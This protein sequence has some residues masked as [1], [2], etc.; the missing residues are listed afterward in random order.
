MKPRFTAASL[1]LL[2]VSFVVLLCAA[3]PSWSM[4][5]RI[6]GNQLILSGGITEL[7][8]VKFTQELIPAVR[9][10]VLTDSPGGSVSSALDIADDIRRK[11]LST[12][13]RGYCRSACA[14]IFLGGVQRT[15][16]DS[17]SHVDFHAMYAY[18]YSSPTQRPSTAR[19]GKIASFLSD[20][21]GG[22]LSDALIKTILRKQRGG[23]VYFFR[24]RTF[25]CNGD[26]PNRPSGCAKLPQTA[27]DQGVITSL[28]NVGGTDQ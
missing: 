14:L 13:I 10:I 25:N 15:L 18:N 2:L 6:E 4:E 20:M 24:D 11:G 12:T 19:Y 17:K 9:Q 27:L 5:M 21:T 8:Y 22:K 28:D 7:D 26:E 3:A 1:F 23:F 16:A